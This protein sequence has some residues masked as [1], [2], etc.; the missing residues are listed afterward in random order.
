MTGTDCWS[1]LPH[2]SANT[3]KTSDISRSF[4]VSSTNSASPSRLRKSHSHSTTHSTTQTQTQTQTQPSDSLSSR[5]EAEGDKDRD[6]G[7]RDRDRD[8]GSYSQREGNESRSSMEDLVTSYF[9]IINTSRRSSPLVTISKHHSPRRSLSGHIHHRSMS[10]NQSK[11]SVQSGS[12]SGSGK[13]GGGIDN[14]W[15]RHSIVLDK[16]PTP[17]PASPQFVT[18]HPS[19]LPALLR[20]ETDM[21]DSA[22]DPATLPLKP[23]GETEREVDRD[24]NGEGEGEEGGNHNRKIHP[25]AQ[26]SNVKAEGEGGGAEL[27]V[28]K[29]GGGD[30]ERRQSIIDD[31][32]N[33]DMKDTDTERSQE[34][35]SEKEKEKEPAKWSPMVQLSLSPMPVSVREDRRIEGEEVEREGNKVERRRGK[36]G[37]R[38]GGGKGKRYYLSNR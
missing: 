7:D 9:T 31:I 35:E 38:E 26:Y 19:A 4:S 12:G 23:E 27:G 8:R 13:T 29:E 11:E 5:T 17:R 22:T 18:S 14:R 16:S 1:S 28:L 24:R 37:E 2:K 3:I 20:M 21:G 33:T 15:P 32:S 34:Q 10:G 30:R 36:G 6:K 25:S